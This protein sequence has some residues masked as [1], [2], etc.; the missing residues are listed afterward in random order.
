MVVEIE[1]GDC[2]AVDSGVAIATIA[3]ILMSAN[4]ILK[5]NPG[6]ISR[7]A[8]CLTLALCI[9][10]AGTWPI[11]AATSD[12]EA[13]E[14]AVVSLLIPLEKQ[15]FDFRA[16]VWERELKPDLGKAVRLQLFKGNDYRVC[17]AVPANSGVEIEAHVVDDA[18]KSI[19]EKTE[20]KGSALTLHVKPKHTGVYMVTIN[21]SGGKKI[22]VTCAM[23]MGYK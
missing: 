19:E 6:A 14:K 8:R 17:I 5:A 3:I 10:C 9:L 22:P 23:I 20:G 4:V 12:E 13:A 1:K 18:G 21:Q 11:N 2:P 16:D 15:G 7:S